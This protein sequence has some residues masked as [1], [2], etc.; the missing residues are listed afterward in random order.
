MKIDQAIVRKFLN[1]FPQETEEQIIRED[2]EA[3]MWLPLGVAIPSLLPGDVLIIG[4]F[5]S[6]YQRIGMVHA[7]DNDGDIY[8]LCQDIKNKARVDL[9]CYAR[10]KYTEIKWLKHVKEQ[11]NASTV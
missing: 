8:F 7:I 9:V 3:G 2:I 1:N 5:N 10:D 11:V 6:D 4:G